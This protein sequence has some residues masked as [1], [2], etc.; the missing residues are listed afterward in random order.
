MH[1]NHNIKKRELV[2]YSSSEDGDSLKGD[3][4]VESTAL[5]VLGLT[6]QEEEIVHEG[7][8]SLV[9]QASRDQLERLIAEFNNTSKVQVMPPP[10]TPSTTAVA[11]ELDEEG[12]LEHTAECLDHSEPEDEQDLEEE[13]HSE[14]A[15]SEAETV[16]SAKNVCT[17][18]RTRGTEVSHETPSSDK[19]K[20][21][22]VRVAIDRSQKPTVQTQ[23]EI[24]SYPRTGRR[25]GVDW[26]RRKTW[27]NSTAQW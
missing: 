21:E 10:P 7:H 24:E 13:S 19:D 15:E 22:D 14:Y 2:D 26:I 3:T 1:T 17:R 8:E 6:S 27:I 5:P 4:I 16:D 9:K 12:Q 11:E 20:D 25:R 18:A 23:A